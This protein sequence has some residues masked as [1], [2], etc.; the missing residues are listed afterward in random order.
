HIRNWLAFLA[1]ALF[2]V[3]SLISCVSQKRGYDYK[4]HYKRNK[5]GGKVVI[6]DLTRYKCGSE[7]RR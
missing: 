5:S 2:M 6:K 1:M 4:G 7:K 3:S